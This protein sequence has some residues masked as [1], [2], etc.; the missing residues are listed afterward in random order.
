MYDARLAV[1]ESQ[2]LRIV[3]DMRHVELVYSQ[4]Y[5]SITTHLAKQDR[6]IY[7]GFGVVATLQFVIPIVFA[8]LKKGP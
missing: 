2:I 5:R 3:E 6:M 4:D 8:I 7:I 1:I